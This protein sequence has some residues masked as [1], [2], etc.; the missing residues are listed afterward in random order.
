MVKQANP[1]REI[2][3]LIVAH[4]A[5]PAFLEEAERHGVAVIQSYE[6]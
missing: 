3:P 5:R 1:G 4:F 2:A 6:W